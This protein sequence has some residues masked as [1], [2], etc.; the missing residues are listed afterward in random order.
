MSKPNGVIPKAP[1]DLTLAPAA[2][3]LDQALARLR[4]MSPAEI[5]FDL[6]LELDSAEV[7]HSAAERADRILR[8]AL[9]NVDLHGW[10]AEVTRDR[11]RVRLSGGSVSL[12]L[13][14]SANLIAFIE[15]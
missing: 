7:G 6:E 8:A 12:D 9:R 4:D 2:V 11:A 15:G 1:R 13:G 3:A 10:K 5:A 14:L